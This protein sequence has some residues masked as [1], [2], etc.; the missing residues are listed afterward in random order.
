MLWPHHHIHRSTLHILLD[1]PYSTQRHICW[2]LHVCI[3]QHHQIKIAS[4][5]F[6]NKFCDNLFLKIEMFKKIGKKT[7][8]HI[9]LPHQTHMHRRSDDIWPSLGLMT[10]D[11]SFSIFWDIFVLFVHGKPTTAHIPSCIH[12]TKV[13]IEKN[14]LKEHD[15]WTGDG[16]EYMFFLL[17]RWITRHAKGK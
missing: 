15:I 7:T 1:N 9:P 12:C 17:V 10:N 14:H 4:L 8:A 2:I 11:G 16:V 3:S 5:G 6:G 13:L